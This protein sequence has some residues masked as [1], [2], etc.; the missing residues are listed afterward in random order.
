MQGQEVK[1]TQPK[2]MKIRDMQYRFFQK[3][4][5]VSPFTD[6]SFFFYCTIDIISERVIT[7]FLLL[8]GMLYSEEVLLLVIVGL[9][10]PTMYV[11]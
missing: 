8:E 10:A 5:L 2:A 3:P 1:A 11:L 9:S 7:S 6:S 4:L